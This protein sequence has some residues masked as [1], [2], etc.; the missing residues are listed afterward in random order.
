MKVNIDM[1][2]LS[3]IVEQSLEKNISVTVEN[4]VSDV[5]SG[6]INSTY[7]AEIENIVNE[8]M[9]DYVDNYIKTATITV[10]GGFDI[11]NNP[12]ETYTVEE[13]INK[14]LADIMNKQ[15]FKV[16]EKTRYGD[17]R[18]DEVTFENFIKRSF[19]V[20]EL[21]QNEL[22]SFMKKTKNEI[23]KQI[24]DTLDATTRNM[25]SETVF[26]MLMQSDTYG[27]LSNG[28]KLL[29]DKS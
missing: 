17:Y 23:N 21:I 2:N 9:K 1:E 14:Q 5:I 26:N 6:Y 18:T 27:R 28:L 4:V 10:G 16:E 8:K 22:N 11:K 24:K 3:S 13:Y 7:K 15:S 12:I 25:L 29:E 20:N 19:N